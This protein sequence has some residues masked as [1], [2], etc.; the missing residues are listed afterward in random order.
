MQD[1][2]QSSNKTALWT[3]LLALALI[4]PCSTVYYAIRYFC[5]ETPVS[6]VLDAMETWLLR[7]FPLPESWMFQYLCSWP[8]WLLGVWGAYLYVRHLSQRRKVLTYSLLGLILL[9]NVFALKI[10]IVVIEPGSAEDIALKRA[11]AERLARQAI[12]EDPATEAWAMAMAHGKVKCLG[13]EHFESMRQ[14]EWSKDQDYR[15]IGVLQEDGSVVT[16]TYVFHYEVCD[17]GIVLTNFTSR[18]RDTVNELIFKM[19]VD[20]NLLN[21]IQETGATEK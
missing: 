15:L 9:L 6:S 18:A 17:K 16:N 20:R 8:V 3:V 12:T 19:E 11:E 10:E 14:G 2:A 5:Q 7:P 21:P 13:G 1:N 4:G